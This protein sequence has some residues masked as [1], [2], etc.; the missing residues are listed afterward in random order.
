VP[1]FDSYGPQGYRTQLNLALDA[2]WGSAN[3]AEGAQADRLLAFFT[4]QGLDKYGKIFQLDGTV[5]DATHE[6]GLVAANGALAIGSSR[7]N[8]NDFVNAV[9][10]MAIPTGEPRY[11]DG[12]LYLVSLLVLSGQYRVY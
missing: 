4:A 7:A 8:R 10:T 2:L 9:W 5:L 3:T 6:Q 11:Y 1:N 12:I